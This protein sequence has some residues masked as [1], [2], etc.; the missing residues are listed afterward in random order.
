M[1][2]KSWRSSTRTKTK[3]V[4]SGKV[5]YRR[6]PAAMKGSVQECVKD[7]WQSLTWC[8]NRETFVSTRV[9]EQ[10]PGPEA[11]SGSTCADEAVPNKVANWCLGSNLQ[12]LVN[13]KPKGT[14][15]TDNVQYLQELQLKRRIVLLVKYSD[16]IGWICTVRARDGGLGEEYKVDEKSIMS[17]DIIAALEKGKSKKVPLYYSEKQKMLMS[18]CTNGAVPRKVTEW[19]RLRSLSEVVQV[20]SVKGGQAGLDMDANVDFTDE[21][22][23]RWNHNMRSFVYIVE[24]GVLDNCLFFEVE[25]DRTQ[26]QGRQPLIYSEKWRTW[27]SPGLFFAESAEARLPD[28]LAS[29]LSRQGSLPVVPEPWGPG[30]LRQRSP[31]C[32]PNQVEKAAVR[33]SGVRVPEAATALGYDFN[34]ELLLAHALTHGPAGVLVAGRNM[35]SLGSALLDALLVCE[36][37]ERADF[38]LPPRG[39]TPVGDSDAPEF[40]TFDPRLRNASQLLAVLNA[41]ANNVACAYAVVAAGL[42]TFIQ[43]CTPEQKEAIG[44]FEKFV[45]HLQRRYPGRSALPKLMSHDAPRILGDVFFSLVA[46]VLY[47]SH[48]LNV[49]RVFQPMIQKHLLPLGLCDD[50]FE[51]DGVGELKPWVDPVRSVKR[52]RGAD[53]FTKRAPD[54]TTHEELSMMAQSAAQRGVFKNV[55]KL[56]CAKKPLEEVFALRDF[57]AY[58]LEGSGGP[59]MATSPRA[60]KRRCALLGR[61]RGPDDPDAYD[62]DERAG[63]EEVEEEEHDDAAGANVAANL[64]GDEDDKKQDIYC[65]VCD[66]WLNG[67]TQFDDHTIGKKHKKNFRKQS[68]PDRERRPLAKAKAKSKGD[69]SALDKGAAR[70]SANPF[71]MPGVPGVPVTWDPS[72]PVYDPNV[73]VFPPMAASPGYGMDP[74]FYM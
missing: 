12:S 16:P 46:A 36:L 3:V 22:K 26:D 25:R 40:V 14:T 11:E 54:N 5:T 69:Q 49:Q 56:T 66:M 71:A 27:L 9:F 37:K 45:K 13:V 50:A 73:S 65:D 20:Q 57:H 10:D 42:H 47:D 61:T 4:F 7:Q 43:G 53:L 31:Y 17:G 68:E 32:L 70:S 48:W 72:M 52:E 38:Y 44:S 33:A 8:R 29:W 18:D 21:T 41:C 74:F 63:E 15:T 55:Y 24:R 59:V 6:A 58:E 67:P 23:P 60:A 62:L 39:R 35:K 30:V 64:G 28:K 34:N 51:P 1:A 2:S 19:L